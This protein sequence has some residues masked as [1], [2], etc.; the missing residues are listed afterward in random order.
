MNSR[1]STSMFS[2]MPSL[3][4]DPG[5]MRLG[6]EAES[7][8]KSV[9]S[10]SSYSSEVF[11]M[12]DPDDRRRYCRTMEEIF[13]KVQAGRTVIWRNEFGT[14]SMGDGSSKWHRYLEWSDYDV[15]DGTAKPGDVE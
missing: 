5:Q 8:G 11:N 10:L 13:P 6:I 3:Y 4:P 12:M 9:V 14:L 1:T 7:L 2:G 15:S